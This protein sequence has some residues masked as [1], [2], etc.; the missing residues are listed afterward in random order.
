[1]KNKQTDSYWL[2]ERTGAWSQEKFKKRVN[3]KKLLQHFC[4]LVANGIIWDREWIKLRKGQA[5][6]KLF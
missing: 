4:T 5:I 6:L 1:M 3:I 2:G